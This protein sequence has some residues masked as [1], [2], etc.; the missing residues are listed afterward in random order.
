[1][2]NRLLST[3]LALCMVLTLLP[4]QAQA[5]APEDLAGTPALTS[6]SEKPDLLHTAAISV[7]DWQVLRQVNRY[8]MTMNL[9]PLSVFDALQ[10]S[11]NQRAYELIVQYGH[12]RPD[13][14]DAFTVYADY[15]ITDHTMLAAEN[16]AAGHATST[17]VM[18]SWLK[19]EEHRVN[20][21]NPGMTHLGVGYQGA[22]SGHP[23]YWSQNFIGSS[24]C[25]M[26]NLQLS[27]S[28]VDGKPGTDLDT[29]L[30]AADITATAVCSQHGLCR[31]PLIA[32]MCGGYNI[33]SSAPQTLTVTYGGQAVSLNITG[34]GHN[35][36]WG[37]GTVTTQETCTDNGICTYTCSG[38]GEIKTESIPAKGHKYSAYKFEGELTGDFLCENC[39]VLISKSLKEAHDAVI[40]L[41]KKVY[42]RTAS[43]D[44][45]EIQKYAEEQVADRLS[46]W[47]A[48]SGTV[49]EISCTL[50]QDAK[51]G[52][53]V[54]TVTI[55]SRERAALSGTV[56]TAPLTL[57]LPNGGG[58]DAAYYISIP[59]PSGGR[60][61]PSTH[62]AAQGDSITLSVLADDGY[63]FDSL[64]VTDIHGRAVTVRSTSNGKYSF[65][66]P[67]SQ[68]IV[69]ARFEKK[70]EKAPA[71]DEP[72]TEIGKPGI[73]G[74]VLNPS[75]MP[76]TDV[77][78]ADWYYT[79]VDYVWKHSLMSGVSDTRFAPASTTSRAVIWTV[80][81]RMHNI[82][83]D[84]N[85]G[86]TWY[87]RG[88]LWAVQQGIS[89]GS[90]PMENITREQL[91]AM[92]WRDAGSPAASGS[93]QHFT[94]HAAVS[95]YAQTAMRWA[96]SN[97]ILQGTNGRLNP[98]GSATRAEAAAMVMRYAENIA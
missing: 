96:V 19:N 57:T 48:F 47:G 70:V 35:H 77:R 55:Q 43:Q 72:F 4:G 11:A 90:G 98:K 69:E 85:P 1:M 6:P 75:P 86:S 95:T 20:I 73:S 13:G 61:T 5:A 84:S 31:L 7:Q 21:E 12:T 22:S 81:A 88:M 54:Y 25:H 64:S 63:I 97:N 28:A 58:S 56:T 45:T 24:A 23:N 16:I 91:A 66:M 18:D 83:T 33:N 32:A 44:K 53:Y 50:P 8:R 49:N 3:L 65:T 10:K 17:A 39:G 68:V 9:Q 40:S 38:C 36:D 82:R 52:S 37:T 74:I 93:L 14:S 15:D 46:V 94:D 78:T 59:N 67:S 30:A 76:F 41:D 89:D 80:L 79:S 92:L 42:P 27:K 51:D 62:H 87:E 60:V 71:D 34:S 26:S 29:L 2:R